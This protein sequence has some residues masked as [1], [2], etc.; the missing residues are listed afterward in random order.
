M[1]PGNHVEVG[2]ADGRTAVYTVDRVRVFDK[3]GFP[4]KEVYGPSKGPNCG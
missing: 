2:R 4:D 3:T 1:K